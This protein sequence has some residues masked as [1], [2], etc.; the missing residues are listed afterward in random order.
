MK[1]THGGVLLLVKLQASVYNFTKSITPPCVFFTLFII[2]KY[3]ITWNKKFWFKVTVLETIIINILFK[4]YA[5]ITFHS[6]K[7]PINVNLP[8][9]IRHKF[10]YKI[11]WN[12]TIFK[13]Y[14]ELS[15]GKQYNKSFLTI[16]ITYDKK[17]KFII[18]TRDINEKKYF[19]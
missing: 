3:S 15:L 4:V 17:I 13:P 9:E 1:N 18:I 6:Y 11:I 16:Q 8:N 10:G 12:L 2:A 14:I 19:N 5:T 7:K